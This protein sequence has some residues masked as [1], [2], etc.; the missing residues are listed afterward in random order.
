MIEKK[1]LDMNL[2]WPFQMVKVF[3]EHSIQEN[4]GYKCWICLI[5]LSFMHALSS[6]AFNVFHIVMFVQNN[7]SNNVEKSIV[8]YVR[9]WLALDNS[10]DL[11]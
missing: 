8:S 2:G 3:I 1:I 4:V 5:R 9:H 7:C 6:L 10:N 11:L